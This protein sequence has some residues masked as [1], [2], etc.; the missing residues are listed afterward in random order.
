MKKTKSIIKKIKADPVST[1]EK[2]I[3]S[4]EG[5]QAVPRPAYYLNTETRQKFYDVAGAVAWPTRKPGGV[6]IVGIERSETY[7]P[8]FYAL[9]RILLKLFY[10]ERNLA[11]GSVYIQDHNLNFIS[12]CQKFVG[13]AVFLRP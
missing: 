11:A 2:L 8:V 6:I 12:N 9:P 4:L 1:S 5:K 3:A 10:S 7:E 13:R